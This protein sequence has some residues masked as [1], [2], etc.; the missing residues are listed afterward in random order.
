MSAAV[1]IQPTEQRRSLLTAMA[2]Q[3]QME[4]AAFLATIKATVMPSASASN[5]QVAAFLAVAHQYRLNPFTREVY[6]FPARSGGVQAVVSVDGWAK[7]INGHDDFD[8]MEFVDHLEN[9]QV[10]SVTC[11]MYRK[12]RA[13]PVEVTEYM[14]ECK[15]ETDT[16]KHWPRRMLRHK[17]M[18]QCARYAFG[19]AGI[20]DPD[21]AERAL[22]V[23]IE[24]PNLAGQ[25]DAL[26]ARLAAVTTPG[27]PQ[28]EEPEPPTDAD[29]A[30][31]N[32]PPSDEPPLELTPP[33][34]EPAEPKK[35]NTRADIAFFEVVDKFEARLRVAAPDTFKAIYQKVVESFGVQ[36]R[37][38]IPVKVRAEFVMALEAKCMELEGK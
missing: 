35:R 8:G 7:L 36:H 24:E 38:E 2:A 13:H 31:L 9:S 30:F 22:E 37:T 25:V 23:T 6:A 11:R 29:L 32:A 3:F 14:A 26:K 16:W 4:P 19:F 10:L 21:E 5:E 20:V 33:A 15:R 27:A 28:P 1:A 12:S 17:A 18:I 34:P